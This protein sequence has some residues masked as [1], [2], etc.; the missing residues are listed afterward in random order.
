MCRYNV[1]NVVMCRY[2]VGNVV[3]CECNG[4][5]DRS[6]V[7]STFPQ[8][9]DSQIPTNGVGVFYSVHVFNFSHGSLES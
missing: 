1:G 3:M 4:G 9:R 6:L 7:T 2:N 8:I 5:N